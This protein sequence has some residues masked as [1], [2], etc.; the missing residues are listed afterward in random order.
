AARI[1]AASR[2]CPP[3]GAQDPAQLTLAGVRDGAV[4]RRLPGENR[5]SL[6]LQ[7]SGGEGRRW[8]FVNGEPQQAEGAALTLELQQAG[9]YQLVVM[10]DG[11]QTAAARFTLQ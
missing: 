5:A 8:W 1:P 3:L 4:I 7:T 9:E 2:T 10:D 11:G 6:V